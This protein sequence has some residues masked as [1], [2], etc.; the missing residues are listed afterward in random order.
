[1]AVAAAGG[2][3]FS[4]EPCAHLSC[5]DS[6]CQNGG[7]MS[8][9]FSPTRPDVER[10]RSMRALCVEMNQRIV[11]TLPRK[12]YEE[13]GDAIGIRHNGVLVLDNLDVSSVLMDCC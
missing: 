9:P 12:A 3:D 6:F 7:F 2:A 5:S 1:M 8:T 11:E 4:L 13:I 10:Y